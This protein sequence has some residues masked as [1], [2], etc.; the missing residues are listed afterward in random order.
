MTEANPFQA[1]SSETA[2][3]DGPPASRWARLGAALIDGMIAIVITLPVMI[4]LGYELGQRFVPTLRQSLVLFAAGTGGF[5]LIHGY[6][7]AAR[8]QTVGKAALNIRIVGLDGR[9][10]PFGDLL[11][12]R[13]LL[14]WVVTSIPF[15]KWVGLIDSLFVFRSDRRCVHDLIAGTKVVRI[16][17]ADQ[18]SEAPLEPL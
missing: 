18:L 9:L 3:Y 7:L 17:G 1:P 4:A 6:L 2:T 8:G 14:V 11:L 13:Y 5:L 10:R 15:M 16:V 12:K